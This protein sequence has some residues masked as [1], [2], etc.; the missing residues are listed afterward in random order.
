MNGVWASNLHAFFRLQPEDN[1]W[2]VV[3]V[4]N[5]ERTPEESGAGEVITFD[6][7]KTEDEAKTWAAD[8][9]GC[10]SMRQIWPIVH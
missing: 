9:M 4:G 6:F 5:T 2:C 8:T 3:I 7:F 10:E 1:R